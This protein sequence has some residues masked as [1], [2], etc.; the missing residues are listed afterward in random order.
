MSGSSIYS[1]FASDVAWIRNWIASDVSSLPRNRRAAGIYFTKE[2]LKILKGAN[3]QA[4][5]P[6]VGRPVPYAAFWFADAFSLRR[7]DFVRQMALC[8]VYNSLTTT[9]KDDLEDSVTGKRSTLEF[10]R[11]YWDGRCSEIVNSTIPSG[12]AYWEAASIAEE[13]WRRYDEWNQTFDQTAEFNPYSDRFLRSSSRYFVAVVFPPL[14]AIAAEAGRPREI[15][16]IHQFLRAFSKGWRVFDDLMDWQRD[17][18]SPRLNRSSVLYYLEKRLPPKTPVKPSY[19]LSS[20]LSREFVEDT[21][22]AIL[23]NLRSAGDILVP[24]KNPYL[25]TFIREQIEFHTKRRDALLGLG[26]TAIASLSS[27]ISRNNRIVP[28]F[29][30]RAA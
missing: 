29:A 22:R 26:G 9:I 6:S 5:S 7:S 1:D 23:K 30:N 27:I 3:Q 11:G 21:Y 14:A 13:E 8:M 25:S 20:F 28:Q 2:R 19:V 10:L 16:R 15:A 18:G 12:S 24:L 17:I 4:V